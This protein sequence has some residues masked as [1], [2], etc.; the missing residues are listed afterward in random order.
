MLEAVSA[1]AAVID[2][3]F[4]Q[5]FSGRVHSVFTKAVYFADGAGRLF[6]L[7]AEAAGD[8]PFAV[9][10][11][12]LAAAALDSLGLAAGD[13]V[14]TVPGGLA[15]GQN[16]VLAGSVRPWAA[17]PA[18]FPGPAGRPRL[19]ANLAVMRRAIAA[20]GVTGGM[21]AWLKGNS[22]ATIIE[23]E[24]AARA[25]ALTAALSG[26]DLAGAHAAG[27]RLIG[28]GTGLTPSGDDFLAGLL[29][30]F[31]M[32]DG[33]FGPAHRE[34]AA[35]LAADADTGAVSRAMLAHAAAGR[36]GA[37]LLALLAAVAE[38]TALQTET[39]VRR[40]VAAGATSGTDQAAGLAGGLVIARQLF[41]RGD[42]TYGGNR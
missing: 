33:P 11:R 38:G 27:R 20:A 2:A 15:F 35:A 7:A 26:G 1:D 39:A 8:G 29:L 42:L 3:L 10:V 24:L 32:A 17:A 18:P 22:G 4:R 28:L 23:R 40:A 31:H 41:E 34:L 6:C 9:R 13:A 21:L 12:T 25:D 36:A 5:P 19:A 14:T 16:L 30:T 37:G